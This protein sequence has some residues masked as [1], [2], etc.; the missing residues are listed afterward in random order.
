MF[1]YIKFLRSFSKL[2]ANAPAAVAR[3]KPIRTNRTRDW[4]A[5]VMRLSGD[6]CVAFWQLDR[7]AY[8]ASS[9][10]FSHLSLL[11]VVRSSIQMAN[12]G[13]LV[14]ISGQHLLTTGL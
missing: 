12:S 7:Y 9:S 3:N 13:I 1:E 6:T 14:R 2:Y 10:Y 11:A 4:S 5:S 8:P